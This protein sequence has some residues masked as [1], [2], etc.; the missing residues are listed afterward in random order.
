[1]NIVIFV[2]C[3][4]LGVFVHEIGHYIDEKYSISSQDE[5]KEY[6]KKYAEDYTERT[7]KEGYATTSEKEFFAILY[8]EMTSWSADTLEIPDDL[9]E[10]MKNVFERT[11]HI[12][13]KR[14]EATCLADYE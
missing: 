5:F 14:Y 4:Y 7:T 9:F 10:Y 3:L 13:I 1:M 2:L 6:F 8:S 11:E 12:S